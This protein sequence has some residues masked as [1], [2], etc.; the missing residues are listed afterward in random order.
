MRCIREASCLTC[1]PSAPITSLHSVSKS[2]RS[3]PEPS[4]RSRH[5]IRVQLK[6][7]L[8]LLRL[9]TSKLERLHLPH[10]VEGASLAGAMLL[11]PSSFHRIDPATDLVLITKPRIMLVRRLVKAFYDAC[12][13][14][15]GMLTLKTPSDLSCCTKE[16]GAI[17][18]D[19][20]QKQT[21]GA[22]GRIFRHH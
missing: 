2:L 3:Y 5:R 14:K 13:C 1:S 21:V 9:P 11:A 20:T 22:E 4:R 8:R 18:Q 16:E 19:D 15:Y 17:A 12:R 7:P 6:R 10:P